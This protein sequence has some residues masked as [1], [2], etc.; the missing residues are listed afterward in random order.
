M[1]RRDFMK[2]AGMVL[3]ASPLVRCAEEKPGESK[4]PNVVWIMAEDISTELACYGHPA[5]KTPNLD[6]L[7]RQGT[8]YTHAFCTAP[9]CTPSRNA[10]MTGVYQT[11]T[12]TQ[13]QRRRGVTLPEDIKPITHLLRKAGYYTA[14]G[15]GYSGKTDLNFKAKRLFDGKDWRTRKKDQPFFAQISL[16]ITHRHP[17][18]GWGAVRKQ[19]KHPVDPEDVVLPPYFPDDPVCRMDWAMYLDSI[20]KMD[21]QVG[22]ILDRLEKEG[23]ADNTVV[24]FIGDN[25][26]C[27]LRAKCWLYDPGIRVPLIIRWP[28]NLKSGTVNDDVISMIDLSATILDIS[29]VKLPEYLDGHPIIGPRAGKREHIFAARDLIDEVMDHIR[30]V[31]TKRF[32]YIRNYTPEN[33]YHECKYVRENRPMLA[34]IKEMDA[35]GKLTKAQQLLLAKTKPKEEFY[36]LQADPHELKNLAQS[37]QHRKTL[38]ELRALLDEWIADTKDKGLAQMKSSDLKVSLKP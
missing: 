16:N 13:D 37:Q 6:N 10:M 1:H 12:D 18:S 27:H 22:E 34:L 5:V 19:S 38:K 28:G 11:R 15:C 14:L 36:D 29:G 9:S 20:E 24:I 4:Q 35:Q 31:R 7:A 21:A 2:T 23:I 25:G 3:A 32:K 8:R 17:K 26:R 33:G 30:C